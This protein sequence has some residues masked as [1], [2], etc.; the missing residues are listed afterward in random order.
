MPITAIVRDMHTQDMDTLVTAAIAMAIVVT[1]GKR[2]DS[3]SVLVIDNV[4]LM[5]YVNVF[6]LQFARIVLSSII[7]FD[8]HG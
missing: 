7:Q 4:T 5:G 6:E 3:A 8:G 2:V 1:S